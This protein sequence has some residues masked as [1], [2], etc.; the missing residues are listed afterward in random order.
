MAELK[1]RYSFENAAVDLALQVTIR[2][3]KKMAKQFFFREPQYGK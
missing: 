3:D 2:I 1:D